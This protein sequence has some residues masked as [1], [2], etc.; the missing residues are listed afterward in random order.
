MGTSGGSD[1]PLIFVEFGNHFPR[2][3]PESTMDSMYRVY[4][5]P[6]GYAM[7]PPWFPH[8]STSKQPETAPM[9]MIF[10]PDYPTLDEA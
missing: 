3:L 10:T 9:S 5:F 8:A 6:Y 4:Q 7:V 2:H 1:I